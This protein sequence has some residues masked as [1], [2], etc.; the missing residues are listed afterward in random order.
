MHIFCLRCICRGKKHRQLP[1]GWPCQSTLSCYLSIPA[2]L[3]HVVA[4]CPRAPG[5]QCDSHSLLHQSCRTG[6]AWLHLDPVTLVTLGTMDR[7]LTVGR[8]P[9]PGQPC[10]W[11]KKGALSRGRGGVP[12][13]GWS[14]AAHQQPPAEQHRATWGVQAEPGGASTCRV[15]SKA[16]AHKIRSRNVQISPG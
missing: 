5:T 4:I 12:G 13:H 14:S 10:R 2:L 1:A 15:K 3:H 16:L 8:Q 9:W 7:L 6:A 11:V